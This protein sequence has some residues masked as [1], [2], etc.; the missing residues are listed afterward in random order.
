MPFSEGQK[1]RRRDTKRDRNLKIV[2]LYTSDR[3]LT[4]EEIGEQFGITKQRVHQIVTKYGVEPRYVRRDYQRRNPRRVEIT[5]ERC[6][7][8]RDVYPS[9]KDQ[10]YCSRACFH[11]AQRNSK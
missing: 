10:K 5:C 8:K 2:E 1:R 3:G 4:L 6:G 9:Q 11:A 7:K